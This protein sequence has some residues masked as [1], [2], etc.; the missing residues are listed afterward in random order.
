MKHS[1]LSVLIFSGDRKVDSSSFDK[2]VLAQG[3]GRSCA[4][5]LE[6]EFDAN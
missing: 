1:N 4:Y 3:I 6:D 5:G 2:Q